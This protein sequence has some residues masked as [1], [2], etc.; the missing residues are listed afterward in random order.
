MQPSKQYTDVEVLTDSQL[1]PH[2]VLLPAWFI[3]QHNLHQ[4]SI[5]RVAT[6][7]GS[8]HLRVSGSSGTQPHLCLTVRNPKIKPNRP[9]ELEIF[10]GIYS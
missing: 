9:V 5:V 1:N 2:E 10:A 7:C 4:G 3:D 6:A 8:V